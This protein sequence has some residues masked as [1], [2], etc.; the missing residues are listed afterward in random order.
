MEFEVNNFQVPNAFIDEV[1][2][3]LTGVELKIYL[4]IIRFTTGWSEEA[5]GVTL[6]KLCSITGTTNGIVI[7]GCN[8]LIEK[9]LIEAIKE[10]GKA[11]HYVLSQY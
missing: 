7:K 1:I 4:I 6:N 8:S 11:T 10:D 9:E 2:C 5:G 3:D